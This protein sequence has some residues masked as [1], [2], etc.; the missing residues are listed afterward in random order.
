[1]NKRKLREVAEGCGVD[2][3]RLLR[4]VAFTWVQ[5][6]EEHFFDEE[7][8]ARARFILELQDQ[9]GVNDEA[10]PIILHLVDQ[11]NRVHWELRRG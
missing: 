1:M 11:L 3:A 5:P 2:E 7:D 6:E 10:V 8:I 9:L 4:L